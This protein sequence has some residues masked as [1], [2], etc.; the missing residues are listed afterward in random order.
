M[1]PA[2]F[3]DSDIRPLIDKV[4][5]KDRLSFDD[6]V[7]LFSTDDLP[8]LGWIANHVREQRHGDVTY[9]LKNRH[10]NYSNVC[11]YDCFFCSFFRS[12][13]DEEGAWEWSVDDV[14]AHV[15]E[16]KDTGLKEFHIVGGVHPDLPF[17]Y[18]TDM[19][20]ALRREHPG[21]AIKAFTAIEI[22]YFAE[23]TGKSIRDVLAELKDAG[24]DMLPGGGAEVFADRVRYKVCR[25]KADADRW[26]DVHEAAHDLQIPTTCTM[27]YG[28]IE[29]IEERVDHLMRLRD[30]QDRTGGL[31]SYIPLRFHPDNNKLGSKK[32]GEPS[33]PDVLKNIAVGRLLLDNIEHVKAYWVM[34]GIKPAQLAL[35]WG[36]NDLD[37]TVT[38][39]RIYH[40]A[41]AKTPENMTEERLRQVITEAGRTPVE[42][43]AFY[44]RVERE[45]VAAV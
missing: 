18:Y 31:L 24:L 7:K 21:V 6:G 43:D 28:H 35:N 39:E 45:E 9:Y 8:A 32:L 34:L 44:N 2:V 41:G 29:T 33:G 30:L 23:L 16:Y 42:R 25:E 40:M 17:T 37:G 15:A 5:A 26:F 38:W 20:S 10:I 12:S 3:A 1:I 22:A 27:L 14:L 13:A 4:L 19:L 11:K 36:A